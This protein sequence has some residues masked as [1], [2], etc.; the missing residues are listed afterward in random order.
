MQVSDWAPGHLTINSWGMAHFY[1]CHLVASSL[2][3]GK[4]T[5]GLQLDVSEVQLFY[6]W[7]LWL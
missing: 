3:Y 7:L 1:S 6:L 2:W 4:I 5:E